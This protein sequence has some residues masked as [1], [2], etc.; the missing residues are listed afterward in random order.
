V[1]QDEH[2]LGILRIELHVP[3]SIV[4]QISVLPASPVNLAAAQARAFPH[5]PKAAA[6][7]LKSE[8]AADQVSPDPSEK[9]SR[10]RKHNQR[11][12]SPPQTKG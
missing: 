2:R 6:T 5:A 10:R 3:S 12:A 7:D 4:P 11:V 8:G 9:N 1:L